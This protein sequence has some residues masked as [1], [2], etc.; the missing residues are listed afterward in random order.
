[1]KNALFFVLFLVWVF[2]HGQNNPEVGTHILTHFYSS[3]SLTFLST[4][5]R[6][7]QLIF[8]IIAESLLKSICTNLLLKRKLSQIDEELLLH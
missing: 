8:K 2:S 3:L 1:M 4:F 7:V 5:L 6:T